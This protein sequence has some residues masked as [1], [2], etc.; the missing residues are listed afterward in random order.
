MNYYPELDSHIKDKV[1][2]ILGVS[3]YVT[4]KQLQYATDID[5]FDLAVEKIIL[6]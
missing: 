6:L 5:K 2:V 3:N 1:K 4:K